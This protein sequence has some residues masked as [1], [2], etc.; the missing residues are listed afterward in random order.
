MGSDSS[1]GAFGRGRAW[2]ALLLACLTLAF[3]SPLLQAG[4]IRYDDPV[5]VTEN[6]RVQ[7]GLTLENLRWAFTTTYF[8]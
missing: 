4:F 3:L 7:A 8:G 1:P 5:Y 6:L 2:P